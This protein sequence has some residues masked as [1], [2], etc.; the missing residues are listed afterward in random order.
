MPRF[1]IAGRR[2]L[3]GKHP[4][5]RDLHQSLFNRLNLFTIKPGM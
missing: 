2:A 1:L 4:P 5:S 3:A